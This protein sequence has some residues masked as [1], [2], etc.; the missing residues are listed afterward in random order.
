[1]S[2]NPAT[3]CN[4]R[5][6]SL[7][8]HLPGDPIALADMDMAGDMRDKLPGTGQEFTFRSEQNST[9]MSILAARKAL[10]EAGADAKDIGLIIPPRRCRRPMALR[11]PLSPFVLHLSWKMLNA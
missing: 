10:E 11:Y 5:L 9:E 3:M 7:E 2:S 8:F 1:M 6:R 4:A